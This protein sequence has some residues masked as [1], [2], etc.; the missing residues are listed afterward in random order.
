ML[1]FSH[2]V[3]SDSL[4]HGCWS[5]NSNTLATRCQEQAH[6]KRPWCWEKLKARGEGDHR[7]WDGCIASPTLWTWVWVSSRRWWW[8]WKPGILQSMGLQNWTRL[9]YW[10]KLNWIGLQ[11]TRS[12]C[13]SPSPRIC[14]ST[15]PLNRWCHPTISSSVTLFSFCLQSFQESGY[16]PMSW[17]FASGGQS[18]GASAL[19]SVFLKSTQ[20]WLPLVDWLILLPCCPRDSQ[21]SSPAPHFFSALPSL[22]SNSHIHT[23]L[24]EKPY[25]WLLEPLMAKWHLCFLT[26]S[27]LCFLNLSYALCEYHN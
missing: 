10:T 19:E 11:H 22:W 18:I 14:P 7:G 24:L 12:P 4:P 2:Q 21:E 5:W 17:L 27:C 9:S 15:Y 8:T 23:W 26:K 13:P 3:V 16:F 6:L 25:P 1:L 20:C